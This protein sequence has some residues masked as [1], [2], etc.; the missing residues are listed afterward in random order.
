MTV[1]FG[2]DVDIK[3]RT[4]EV[5]LEIAVRANSIQVVRFL[6]DRGHD[7]NTIS[8]QAEPLLIVAVRNSIEVARL[9]LK[10][11][12]DPNCSHRKGRTALYEAARF[13]DVLELL[14]AYGAH[15][16][17][18]TALGRTTLHRTISWASDECLDVL[19]SNG[20]DPFAIDVMGRS[21][22]S[23]VMKRNDTDAMSLILGHLDRVGP[24]TL[25]I[26][27]NPNDSF[28]RTKRYCRR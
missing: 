23:S 1:G 19:L 8:I 16:D 12:A 25:C 15:V 5:P 27:E 21:P 4:R 14:I 9:L 11:G 13:K 10:A 26:E 2:D 28:R 18:P 24:T 6:L 7:P 20:A 22:F 17:K 3:S